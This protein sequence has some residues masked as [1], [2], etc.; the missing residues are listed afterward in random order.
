MKSLPEPRFNFERWKLSADAEKSIR[1]CID[2]QEPE[3]C[4]L[5]LDSGATT[6]IQEVNSCLKKWEPIATK[7]IYP[8]PSRTK[9]SLEKLGDRMITVPLGQAILLHKSLSKMMDDLPPYRQF[10]SDWFHGAIELVDENPLQHLPVELSII[11]M[12]VDVYSR[13][14]NDKAAS[15]PNGVFCQLLH[16]ILFDVTDMPAETS[17]RSLERVVQQCLRLDRE[18]PNG[19]WMRQFLPDWIS[20]D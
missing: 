13:T 1:Q 18:D 16:I 4:A 7:C 3:F 6:F 15:S 10:I 11:S 2:K 17:F 20:H 8:E 5:E 9:Q 19:E 14:F 12:L